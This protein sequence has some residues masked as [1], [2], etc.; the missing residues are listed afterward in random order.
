[1]SVLLKVD[2]IKVAYGDFEAL[3]G[4]SLEVEEG[5]IVTIVGANGAGKT[6]ALRAV[7]GL[8]PPRSGTIT[9]AGERVN[10]LSPR[11]LV[12]RGIAL[13][14]EGRQL[15]PSMSVEDNLLVG[16]EA[17]GAARAQANL[18]RMYERLPVLAER[19]TQLAGTLSGGEQQ[20][21]A[22]ARALMSEPRLLLLD[23]PSLGLAPIIVS[24]IFDWVRDIGATGTTVLLVE[25]NVAASLQLAKYAYVLAEGLVSLHGP[26]EEIARDAAVRQAYLGHASVENP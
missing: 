23:E 22:I 6:T 12:Q 17:R 21:A 7:S 1:M 14:P 5:A 16:T 2:D 4:V 9:Y 15:F 11:A 19:R 26:A 18:K 24:Q 8:T 10:G 20:M 13:T 3:H 25:Q